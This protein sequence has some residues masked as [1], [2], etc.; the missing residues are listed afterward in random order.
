M[1][2]EEMRLVHER[3]AIGA[4]ANSPSLNGE[5]VQTADCREQIVRGF[6][7]AYRLLMAEGDELLAEQLPRFASDENRFIARPTS[8]YARLL[9]ESFHPDLLRDALKRDRFFDRLWLGAQPPPGAARLHR[10][11]PA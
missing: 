4:G 6:S 5:D 1:G 10:A 2:T 11:V 7:S 3:V 8:T 9:W